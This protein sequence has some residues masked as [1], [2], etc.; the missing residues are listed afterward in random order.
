MDDLL[1]FSTLKFTVDRR[2]CDPENTEVTA[3][4]TFN[5]NDDV[6]ILLFKFNI[7]LRGES[8]N[9]N[10]P[11][12]LRDFWLSFFTINDG[13]WCSW[14]VQDISDQ[15]GVRVSAQSTTPAWMDDVRKA[16]Q[17]NLSCCMIFVWR[18]WSYTYE[19]VKTHT[20]KCQ[21]TKVLLFTLSLGGHWV[22]KFTK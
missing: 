22:L 18:L 15:H 2:G 9:I 6:D 17:S 13:Q 8:V 10:S 7:R 20:S 4:L 12:N 21:L 11:A 16:R 5:S 19:D 3:E 14:H 1:H